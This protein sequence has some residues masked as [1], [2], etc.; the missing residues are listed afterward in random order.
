MAPQKAW[1]MIFSKMRGGKMNRQLYHS[2]CP[3]RR[4]LLIVLIVT[5]SLLL[6]VAVVRTQDQQTT[7]MANGIDLD[8]TFISRTPL[9][10]T[11]CVLYG[12][13]VP[14][15]PGIPYLCPGTENDRR[16]P[17]P[18]EI[19][20]FTA[21]VVNKGSVA[22]PPFAYAWAIDE[23]VVATGTLPALAPAAEITATYLWP[24][25]HTLSPDGQQAIGQH[26]VRFTADPA[27]L[28]AETHKSNN[29]LRDDTQAMSFNVNFTPAMYQAYNVPVSADIPA[30]A[31][32]WLQ[33]QIAAMNANFANAIYPVTPQGSALRVRLNHIGILDSA[34]APDGLHDGGWF[35][36]AD[37][38]HGGSGWYDPTTDID[39]A[40]IHELSHQVSLIDLYAL[41]LDATSV[42]VTDRLGRP[43]NISTNWANPGL[44][45]GGDITPFTDWRRYSS[46]S[47]GGSH[48]YAG[49]RNGFYGS[50]LFDIPQHNYLRVLDAAGQ[51]AQG[52]QV[53]L[54]QRTGPWDW[55]GQLALDATAEISGTTDSSGL[56]L[57]ANRPVRGGTT[58]ANGHTLR[59]NPFG[60]VDVVGTQGVFLLQLSQGEHEEF[61][62]LDITAFNLAYW[63]GHTISYTLTISSHVPVAN[64]PLPPTLHNIKAAGE[65]SYLCWQASATPGVAAY[66]V[67]RASWP[68]FVYTQ[69]AE[70]GAAERCYAD[71]FASP[72]YDGK[73]YAITAVDE[74]GRESGF[75][76]FGWAPVLINPAAVSMLPQ[77]DRLILDARNGYALI[78]QE[79]NG[80]HRQNVGSVHFHL[81]NSYY[82]ALSADERLIFSHPGDWYD[83]RHSVRVADLNGTPLMEFG[84]I[85]SAP[86][87]F[88]YPAGVAAWG[89]PCTVTGPYEVDEQTLLLL[90]LDGSY[91]G[92][93]GQ[94]GTANGTEFVDGRYAQG[95][96]IDEADTLTYATAG[97]LNRTQGAIEFWLKPAWPGNDL[98]SYT[99]FEVGDQWFN[100]LRMMK[101]GANNLRFM[102]WDSATEYGVAYNVG[103]W[104]A[105]EWHHVAATWQDTTIALYA[106]GIL[107]GREE[108]AHPPDYLSSLMYIGS[109]VWQGQQANAVID[110]LRISN[111]PRLGNS[112]MCGWILVAD[113]GNHRVQAF[114]SLGNFLTAFGQ[115]GSGEGQFNNPQGMAVDGNGRVLVVDH[116]N[117]RVVALE[118][119]GQTF[120]FQ[121]SYT[122]GFNLPTGITVSPGGQIVV[123]D[124]GNDR[125]V[126][127]DPDGTLAHVYEAPNDG[128]PGHF[129]APRG[130]A[131][132]ANGVIVVADTGN[133]R[134]VSILPW[135]TFLPLVQ[136]QP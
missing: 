98:E 94:T 61:H 91:D 105:G 68:R 54:Y 81:E 11:Y 76:N 130:V 111:T 23:A 78:R 84:E 1:F 79:Q 12:W 115:Y 22:S 36:D 134:V 66:R 88:H 8:V 15:Q 129:L 128:S 97:N 43:L 18:G 2:E 112:D 133:R 89:E 108:N 107:V 26:S 80:R 122:A 70:V 19:V 52:V 127:L 121:T 120:A 67:Y 75:S 41:N 93:Q 83:P 65:D 55:P 27:N 50:H 57:L 35:I 90:H 3:W 96:L 99:F 51:P 85:G 62:W 124:T 37:Y 34:P 29:S 44:M 77:G 72:G 7:A 118:F 117:N 131:V 104:Q 110:E 39:W 9:Y 95:V 48:T 47:A 82:M 114:D 4:P 42:Y 63:L 16:W 101:D 74:S 5:T 125:I 38:R 45:G 6:S 109:A 60:V 40:L 24:W 123:A 106:D 20:T 100:R 53:M 116:G 136:G 113:S 102:V 126:L 28:I 13:D 30:S 119:D 46:H 71:S 135:Q 17:E 103:H 49:Y 64:A 21:H 14:N 87:Q 58:T 92:A 59:D 132:Q 73:V 32:D 69:V 33:K 25:G 31:E 86:G 56:F 10:H